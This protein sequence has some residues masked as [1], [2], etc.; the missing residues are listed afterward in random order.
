MKE[1]E[2]PPEKE[3][4]EIKVSILP[5]IE[6]KT[7][8]VRMLKELSENFS[9]EEDIETIK[10]NQKCW[11]EEYIRG[12]HS[13]IDEAEDQASEL[14]YKVAENTQSQQQREKNPKVMKIV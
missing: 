12:I 8:V 1:Q 7:M 9:I 6:F 10:N 4:N 2:K 11:N 13:S 5:D 14:V 3:L